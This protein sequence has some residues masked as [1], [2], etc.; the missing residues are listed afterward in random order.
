M[1]PG[2]DV[3]KSD[4]STVMVNTIGDGNIH[5]IAENDQYLAGLE[6]SRS[7]KSEPSSGCQEITNVQ[8]EMH[9]NPSSGVRN[10]YPVHLYDTSG[11]KLTRGVSRNEILISLSSIRLLSNLLTDK[12]IQDTR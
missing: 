5:E 4:A 2:T 7:V 10:I 3:T 12:A 9:Y 8:K 1:L 11:D 6:L